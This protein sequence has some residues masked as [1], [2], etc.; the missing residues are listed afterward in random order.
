MRYALTGAGVPVGEMAPVWADSVPADIRRAAARF[1]RP[2]GGMPGGS[3]WQEV[4]APLSSQGG[5]D[6]GCKLYARR[7]G[8]G[9]RYAV[10]HSPVYGHGRQAVT[11]RSRAAWWAEE[12]NYSGPTYREDN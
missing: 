1:L 6:Y 9:I 5:C 10:Y 7:W 4:A 2:P 8:R 3:V 12:D 11:V